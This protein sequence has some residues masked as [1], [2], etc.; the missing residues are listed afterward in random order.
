VS[1]VACGDTPQ[2]VKLEKPA[3]EISKPI[4]ITWLRWMARR[5]SVPV[6]PLTCY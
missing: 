2:R 4:S 3:V 1:V 6:R 5:G